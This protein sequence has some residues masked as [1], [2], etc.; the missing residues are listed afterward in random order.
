M[1]KLKTNKNSTK[2]LTTNSRENV[3][4]KDSHSLLVKLQMDTISLEVNVENSQRSKSK[5]TILMSYA[6]P[7]GCCSGMQT[8]IALLDS[9]TF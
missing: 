2:K 4:K 6:M 1:S 7:C 9:V 5:P 3:E 8:I